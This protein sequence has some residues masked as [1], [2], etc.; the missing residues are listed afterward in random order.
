MGSRRLSRV[1]HYKDPAVLE[2]PAALNNRHVIRCLSSVLV[3]VG[4]VP[5]VIKE[6]SDLSLPRRLRVL[7][8]EIDRAPL[9]IQ[10][11]QRL[12]RRLSGCDVVLIQVL[13]MTWL[14]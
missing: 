12:E 4:L 5:C 11:S 10:V 6:E 3:D 1:A 2:E 8:R 14:L 9:R 7:A 13:S